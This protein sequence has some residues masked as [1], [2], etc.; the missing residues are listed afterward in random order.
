MASSGRVV[1][2]LAADPSDAARLRLGQEHRDIRAHLQASAAGSRCSLE[3]R[4]SVRP[5]DLSHAIFDTHPSVV[6]FSGHGRPAGSLQLEDRNGHSHDVSPE[7]LEEL[8]ALFAEEVQ[9]VVLNCCYSEAQ[10]RAIAKRVQFVI[11]MRAAIGDA[12]AIAFAVGFYKAFA[13][14]RTIPDC[15]KFGLAE[16]KLLNIAEHETP[17]LLQ[18]LPAKHLMVDSDE[19]ARTERNRLFARFRVEAADTPTT[20]ARRA[21]QILVDPD[22]YTS[23][24]QLLNDLYESYLADHLKP[25]TY[26]RDWILTIGRSRCMIAPWQWALAPGQAISNLAPRW[27]TDSSPSSLGLKRGSH[28]C[29]ELLPSPSSMRCTV[30]AANDDRIRDSIERSRKHFLM[31][32]NFGPLTRAA[33]ESFDDSAY[34]VKLIVPS[35]EG[36]LL[37]CTD[38]SALDDWIR[39]YE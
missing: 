38:P 13:A 21:A 27:L 6:H 26:G 36:G 23:I 22:A 25:F 20:G 34:H 4:W 29:L 2:F 12:A 32:T 11:G 14:E 1:L 37:V 17:V 33:F 9:C 7:A 15:F 3:A 18:R 8:F 10:A 5:E 35:N 19:E 39:Q 31:L 24:G 16:L 28:G 30:I